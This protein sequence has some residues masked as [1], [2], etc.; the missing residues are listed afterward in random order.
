MKNTFTFLFVLTL[1]AGAYA[2][3]E[4]PVA[5]PTPTPMKPVLAVVTSE[6]AKVGITANSTPM[7]L[8]KAAQTA[9]GGDKFK[10]LKS[11]LIRGSAEISPPG[12][13]QT[14]AATFYM[15]TSGDKSH[16][17][18]N[19]PIAPVTQIFDGTNIYNSFQQ[20]QL[21]PMSRLGISLLQKIDDKDYKVSAV[22][23]RK[24]K[25]GFKITTPDGYATDYYIDAVTGLVDSI[26]AKFTVDG[27]E[28]T[29]SIAHDKYREV[30]GLSIPE[31]FSQ[32]LE[33]GGMSIYVSFKAKDILVNTELPENTFVIPQ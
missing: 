12:S 4:T 24:K 18:I 5:K 17:E 31:K 19:S 10:N 33:F 8:A 16:F 9:H 28:I 3:T 20:V 15:V 14:L 7:E 21:P 22:P 27:K 2:Q 32:R 23:D 13:T 25:R 1:A 29:T 6:P 30:D 11:I 26:E